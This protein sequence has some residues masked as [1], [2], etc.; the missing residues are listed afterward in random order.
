MQISP[1][2]R[3][4]VGNLSPGS[5]GGTAGSNEIQFALAAGQAATDYNFAILGANPNY[6]S[7]RINLSTTGTLA[8][9]LSHSVLDPPALTSTGA[10]GASG[11]TYSTSYTVG[12][13]PVNVARTP[14]SIRRKAVT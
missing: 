4:V 9:Y 1:S 11:T 14:R 13:S 10:T 2:S 8:N 5:A 12:A 3:L 7:A 6:I